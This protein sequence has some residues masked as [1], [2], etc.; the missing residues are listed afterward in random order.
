MVIL[1]LQEEAGLM[2]LGQT[3]QETKSYME[4]NILR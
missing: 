3:Y 4:Q 2:F 1:R